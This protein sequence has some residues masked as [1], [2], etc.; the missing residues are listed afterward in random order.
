MSNKFFIILLILSWTICVNAH[1][2]IDMDPIELQSIGEVL[3]ESYFRNNLIQRSQSIGNSMLNVFQKC[4]CS[5]FQFIGITCSL[6][7]AN[8]LTLMLQQHFDTPSTVNGTIIPPKMCN[9]DFGCD[10]NVCWRTCNENANDATGSAWC[11][12]TP[13]TKQRKYQQCLHPSDCSG[14]WEC[15]GHCNSY[16]S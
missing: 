10:D 12:T 2:A 6:V 1:I 13:N 14:C 9:H 3:V 16:V 4:M 11:Y 7:G 15:L 8:V 5:L